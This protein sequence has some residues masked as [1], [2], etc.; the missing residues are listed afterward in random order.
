MGYQIVRPA[1]IRREILAR[2]SLIGAMKIRRGVGRGAVRPS[3][4]TNPEEE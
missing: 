2:S 3:G 1:E 4:V